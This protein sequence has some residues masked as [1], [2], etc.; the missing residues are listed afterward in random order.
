MYA[1]SKV[2]A[3]FVG[4]QGTYITLTARVVEVMYSTNNLRM[5]TKKKIT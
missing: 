4:I 3:R 2:S 1:E 5:G